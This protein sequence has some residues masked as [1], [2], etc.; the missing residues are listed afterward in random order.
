MI[1]ILPFGNVEDEARELAESLPFESNVLDKKSDLK[2]MYHKERDQYNSMGYIKKCAREGKREDDIVLGVTGVD[3]YSGSYNFV[4]G[5][6]QTGGWG[7]VISLYRLGD[8]GMMME[9]AVKEAVHEIG[10]VVGLKHCDDTNCVMHFSNTLS[11]TDRKTGWYCSQCEER[12]E[13]LV[14]ERELEIDYRRD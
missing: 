10:H 14:D 7:A 13:E 11:D 6:A 1:L 9:R 3:L 5:T 2:Q 8:E 4:F 12:F